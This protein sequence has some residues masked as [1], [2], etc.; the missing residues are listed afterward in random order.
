MLLVAY[1]MFGWLASEPTLQTL[2][3][4]WVIFGVLI[5][6]YHG[7]IPALMSELFPT[8]T[9]TTGLSISY[10]FGVMIFGGFAPF[11][12]SW[13]IEATG[14]KLAPSFYL[15]LAAGISLIALAGARGAGY[16]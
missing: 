7:S 14:S 2:L 15:M 4:V 10:A 1:P 3:W 13:L 8:R 16:R 5:A 6:A 9:R 12:V 11:I